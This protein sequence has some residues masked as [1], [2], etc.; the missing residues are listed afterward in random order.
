MLQGLHHI[1]R[2]LFGFVRDRKAAVSIVAAL[3]L[4]ALIAFSS[5]VGEYG[6]GLLV[7]TEDQRV[8]DLAAYAGALAYNSNATTSSITSAADA[9][10]GLNGIA[11]GN[12]SASLV[13]SPTGDGNSAVLVS[14]TS[15]LPVYLASIVGGGTSL[16]VSASAYAELN[17]QSTG[18]I[19]ALSS[20]GAGVSLTGGTAVT[21]SGCSVA[22][23]ASESVPCGTTITAKTVTYDSSA[24]TQGC[25]GIKG[26]GGAAATIS[27]KL[28]SDPLA[29]TS[30]VTTATGR[31]AT[32]TGFSGPSAPSVT[33]GGDVSFAYS[34][35]STQNQLIADGCTGTYASNTWTVTCTGATSYTFGNITTGGGI[36]VNF[37]TSGAS[38]TT[39]NFSGS[40]DNTGT[41]MTFGP[42]TYNIA[43]GLFTGGGATTT[44]GSGT[45][46]IGKAST[47]CTDGVYYSICNT[48]S[49]L[50]FGANSSFTLQGGV[51]NNGGSTLVMGSSGEGNSFNIGPASSGNAMWLG[52]GATTELGD[53]TNSGSLFQMVGNFWVPSGGGSCT[54]LGAAAEHDIQ[55]DFLTAGGTVLGSGVYTIT[56]YMDLGGSSGGDV[57]CNGTTVGLS[58]AGVTIVLGGSNLPTSGTCS[59]EVFCVAAG[60]NHVALTAPTGSAATAGLVVVGPASASGGAAF[61]EGASNTSLS[62]AFYFPQGPITLSGGASVGGG[63]G[64]C[65][66][67]I[68]T[69]VSLSGGTAAASNCV[70]GG[71]SGG[72]KIAL[73]Q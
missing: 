53:A 17:V 24:P 13:N 12:V 36:T 60:Y 69:Q 57:S 65:L 28:T 29:G 4:P 71:G 26:P 8:A 64:Q 35:T 55:G 14:V 9:V 41:A 19:I 54:Y 6:H 47:K 72:V 58:G 45:Y 48:G 18:C 49:N 61:A 51:Y 43:G 39:Y 31:I 52:G 34:Q 1:G 59:G 67:M 38:T 73:V 23:N 46:D 44:F 5:L 40:I 68:G 70:A 22:S 66:E 20:G 33:T 3:S 25:S 62:G 42:G 37:N 11:S 30:A 56:G 15:T 10:A 63:T 7:K 50:T 2:R 16:P 27:Q 21:A 32:V